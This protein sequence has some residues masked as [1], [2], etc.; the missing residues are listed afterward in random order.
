MSAKAKPAMPADALAAYQ[1]VVA[2]TKGAELKGASMPYTS[3]N[4]NMHS[5]LDKHGVMAVR[6][7]AAD[8]DATLKAGGTAYVHETGAVLKEYVAVPPAILKDAKKASALLA[9][10]LSY[11]KTLKP[12]PTKK[13]AA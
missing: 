1:A 4:G 7:A 11:A 13:K 3:V 6:L 12:K 10:S 5:F 2:A 9:K 8:F